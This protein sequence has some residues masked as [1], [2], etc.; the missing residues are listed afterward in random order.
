MKEFVDDNI[1]F[2][3]DGRKSSKWVENTPFRNCSFPAISPFPTVF[4]KTCTADT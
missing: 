3:E 2:D 4:Q 1:E